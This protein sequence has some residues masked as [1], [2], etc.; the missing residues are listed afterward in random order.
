MANSMRECLRR[1][2]KPSARE[3]AYNNGFLAACEMMKAA[4]KEPSLPDP[5][6]MV[7]ISVRARVRGAAGG[8]GT[9]PKSASI[10]SAC[11]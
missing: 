8:A 2:R 10:V 9:P 11:Q 6:R 1:V 7:D 3:T 4:F 5:K